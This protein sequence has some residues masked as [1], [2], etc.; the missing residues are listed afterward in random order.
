[1]QRKHLANVTNHV[2]SLIVAGGFYMG[3]S[4]PIQAAEKKSYTRVPFAA[5]SS[6]M[7]DALLGSDKY[8]KPVWNLHDALKFPNWLRHR[9][10]NAPATKRCTGLSKPAAKAATSKFPCKP[11]FGWKPTECIPAWH[12]IPGCAGIGFR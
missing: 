3:S 1:M 7:Q 10:N 2:L 12:R 8:E 11:R 6:Q 5:F 4:D 9:W